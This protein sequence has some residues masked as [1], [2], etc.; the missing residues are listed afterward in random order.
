MRKKVK[1]YSVGQKFYFP[2]YDV[3]YQIKSFPT[4]YSVV[5]VAMKESM[6]S[7][8][9]SMMKMSVMDLQNSL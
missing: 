3:T 9:P 2:Q 8:K 1:Q 6:E 7:G 5:L 4:R